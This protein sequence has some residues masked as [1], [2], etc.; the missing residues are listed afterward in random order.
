MRETDAAEMLRGRMMR[1]MIRNQLRMK[2]NG[3]PYAGN[4]DSYFMHNL[5]E[6]LNRLARD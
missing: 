5:R 6:E 3:D 1:A 4:H 2:E